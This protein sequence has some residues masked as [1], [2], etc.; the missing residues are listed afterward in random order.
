MF[1]TGL[2]VNKV[3]VICTSVYDVQCTTNT[4]CCEQTLECPGYKLELKIF[5]K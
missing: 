4:F 1:D 3:R 5:N 2:K